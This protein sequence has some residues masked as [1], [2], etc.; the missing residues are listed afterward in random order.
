MNINLFSKQKA[1]LRSIE[2][3]WIS[4][5]ISAGVHLMIQE[6]NSSMVHGLSSMWTQYTSSIHAEDK[7]ESYVTLSVHSLMS[8][9]Y[10]LTLAVLINEWRPLLAWQ[11]HSRKFHNI[12]QIQSN[13]LYSITW[14]ECKLTVYSGCELCQQVRK[15]RIDIVMAQR[16][17]AGS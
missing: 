10:T 17:P 13:V 9:C 5:W 1:F 2:K 15:K 16:G 11:I 14:L 6:V 4:C 7:G 3:Y 8:Y 12:Q